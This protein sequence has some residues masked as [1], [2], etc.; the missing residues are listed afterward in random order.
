[1]ANNIA[2][3]LINHPQLVI[4]GAGASSAA[5]PQGDKNGKKLSC[6]DGFVKN[7]GLSHILEG[8]KLRTTSENLEEQYTELYNRPDMANIRQRL[9]EGI[10][11]KMKEYILPDEPTVYDY[12][13]A[14]LKG[15]DVI[16]SFNWDSLLIQAYNRILD[17]MP[18]RD[19]RR[20]PYLVF[21]HGNV[22]MGYCGKCGMPSAIQH[23]ICKNCGGNVKASKL[24]Y[25]VKNK[26]YV[27][28]KNINNSWNNFLSEIPN[29]GMITI[30]GY[31]CP[32][33]D[34]EAREAMICAYKSRPRNLESIDIIDLKSKSEVFDNWYEILKYNNFHANIIKQFSDSQLAKY[35]RR[36][37]EGY[38]NQYLRDGGCWNESTIQLTCKESFKELE[39]K[40][41]PLFFD[42]LSGNPHSLYIE[43]T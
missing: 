23:R 13:I 16:V 25:P 37:V 1:M 34:V 43:R 15:G 24:L 29:A 35:P 6:M 19:V 27:K 5:I 14:S 10:I 40:L 36:S 11:S 20:M 3:E 21:V 41:R 8:V 9:E 31:A 42:E 4:L 12:L 28:D 7:M 26:G 33:S 18:L 39:E 30:F 38:V 2:D 17:I 32:K 22:G